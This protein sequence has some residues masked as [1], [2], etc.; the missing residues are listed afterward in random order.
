M[1]N[2]L[3]V[4]KS[5]GVVSKL[6]VASFATGKGTFSDTPTKDY[7]LIASLNAQLEYWSASGLERLHSHNVET[8]GGGAGTIVVVYKATKGNK[9]TISS[10]YAGLVVSKIELK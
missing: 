5:G 1:G 4:R 3:I 10:N 9:W 8:G 2:C 7:Y 6:Q